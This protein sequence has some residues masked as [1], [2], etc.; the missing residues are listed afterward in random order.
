MQRLGGA[1]VLS[2]DTAPF[3]V[4]HAHAAGGASYGDSGA[5]RVDHN[6][7]QLASPRDPGGFYKSQR[8]RDPSLLHKT[9]GRHPRCRPPD[10][11]IDLSNW[12]R[13]SVPSSNIGTG[14]CRVGGGGILICA[15]LQ[16]RPSYDTGQ[17]GS[18]VHT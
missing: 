18:S 15:Y 5:D 10:A 2:R 8:G 12:V 14:D 3:R 11:S 9:P 4:L 16:D 17:E 6:L 13:E 7:M 1:L